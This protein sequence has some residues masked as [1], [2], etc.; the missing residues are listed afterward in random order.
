VRW[1]IVIGIDEYG[2]DDMRLSAAVSDA[3]SFRDWVLA[4]DGGNVPSSNLRLLLG[5]RP[6]DPERSDADVAPTK[7]EIVTAI[8]DVVVGAGA[9]AE[10]LYF[11]FAGH[12]IMARVANRDESAVV[13]PGFDALHTDH[14]LAIRSLTEHLETTPFADQFFLVD[15]C[16]NVPWADRE[17]EIGRWPVP[18]RRDPGASPVQQFILSATSPGSIAAEHG[19]PGEA[20]GAFTSVLMEGFAGVDTAKAWSWERN[21]YEVRWERLATFVNRRMRDRVPE[22]RADVAAGDLPVQIPQDTGSRGVADRDRDPLLVSFPRGRFES[23][24]LRIELR[25]DPEYDEAEVSVLDA[26]GEPIASALKVTG[27]SHTFRLP[28]KTYAVRATTT[29][30]ED[31][32]GSLHAPIELYEDRTAEIELRPRVAPRPDDT[33]GPLGAEDV[34]AGGREEP[35]GTIAILSPDPLALAEIRDETGRVVALARAGD[36]RPATPGFYRIRDLGPEETGDEQF[37]AL[38]AGRRAE[39][40]LPPSPPP[41]CVAALAAALGGKVDDGCLRPVDGAEPVTWALPSTIVAAGIGAA[42]HGRHLPGLGVERLA[43]VLGTARSGVALFAV[44]GVGDAAAVGRL[45]ARAWPVGEPVCR[46]R[47]ALE[48]SAA[49]IAAIVEPIP[50]PTPYWVSIEPEGADPTVVS[51]PVFPGRLATLV[52][53]L[54][55]DRIRLYQLHP[56]GGPGASSTADRLRRVEHLQRLLLAGRLDGAETLAI[57][58][59]NAAGEDPFAGC[60]AGYVLLRIGRHRALEPLV[61]ALVAAAPRLSD[62]YI[63]RGEYEAF[64]GR[65]EGATQAFVDAVNIGIPAFGEGLTR[66]VEGLRASSFVH[67]RGALIRFIFQRHVRG[68][69]WA[70]FTP[71]RPPDRGRLVIS[72]ADLGFEG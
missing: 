55:A 25:A 53:Q 38:S 18:R 72:A 35:S 69:M 19:W 66:L 47:K 71:R 6:D 45:T 43:D 7:D 46:D 64:S 12:G 62:A 67:P 27:T 39:I 60:L 2:H 17:F 70:A 58:L 40:P 30:P 61:T 29:T 63:L 10:R 5:R 15:A 68:S 34:A 65:P 54:D 4:A 13:T 57:E 48:P 42:L 28:P 26:I 51:L 52:A 59:A 56:V 22:P 23:L 24:D 33:S 16:R 21:C 9:R 36:D 1:A 14:S 37:V 49:G 3:V 31:R 11:Y 20:K 8:N 32:V 50:E 44:D 41:P